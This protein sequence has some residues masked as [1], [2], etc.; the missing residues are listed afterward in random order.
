MEKKK[1]ANKKRVEEKKEIEMNNQEDILEA[2]TLALGEEEPMVQMPLGKQY[3]P[4]RE[5][6]TP[7]YRNSND[8]APVNCLRNERILVKFLPQETSMVH[9]KNH[10]LYGGMADSATKSFVV[11]R[12]AS[13][14]M[15]KDVLTNNEKRFLEQAMGLEDNALSVYK[16]KDNFWDDSNNE[17]IGK[18]ILHKKGNY[19]DLSIP[20]DYIKY[21]IL[22][23]NKDKICPS[24][25]ELEERPKATY[26]F[27]IISEN[28]EMHRNLSNMDA[29]M[30]C[31]EE[32]GS[33][34]SDKDILRTI[35]ELVEKKPTSIHAKLDSLQGKCNELIQKDPRKFL[36]VIKDE[37]LPAKVLIKK[38]LEAGIISMKNHLYYLQEN[39]APLCELGE[40]STLNNAAK[41][42]TNI[43]RSELK[44]T[45]EARVKEE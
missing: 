4:E 32:Y 15:F 27:V 17:G 31:Y 6:R 28:D 10:V 29:T 36:S 12:L 1:M 35:V 44:Y 33:V 20:E 24:L 19:L 11:P 38:C 40:N 23:A 18:V 41:Y 30:Q 9:N 8:N 45:L 2:G 13:T 37:L 25:Q 42:I 21:K 7:M 26:Q 16:K 14:G 43:K 39:G 5:A 34:R 3:A 22:L